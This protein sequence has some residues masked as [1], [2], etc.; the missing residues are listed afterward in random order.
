VAA[1]V[2]TA[3]LLGGVAL[4]R[5]AAT[6]QAVAE[7]LRKA[8]ATENEVLSMMSLAN[9]YAENGR[10]AKALK[11][12]EETLALTKVKLGPEHYYTIVNMKKLADCYFAL[13][14]HAEA[15]MLCEQ[16][17]ALMKTKY[18][19]D[20]QNTLWF[21]NGLAST[22]ADYGRHAEALKLQEETLVLKKAKL[23][24]EDPQ[25]LLTMNFLA[26]S[27][28][29]VG[30]H[31]EALKM[32][33]QRLALMR[34]RL[35]P[36]GA[37]LNFVCDWLVLS[38]PLPYE[39]RDGAIALDE[40]QIPHA[41]LLRPR[42]GESFQAG[43]KRLVWKEHHSN[44]VVLDLRALY[45]SPSD[46]RLSYAVCYVHVDADRN[47]L[48]LRVG[49]DDQ[50]S[51]T[52]NGK[53][54]YRRSAG[55]CFEPDDDEVKPIALRKGSNLLVFEVVNQKNFWEGSLHFVAADG[56]PA[57]GLRFGLEP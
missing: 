28:E 56:R 55:R 16:T 52:L 23:S 8:A 40:Q 31:A 25:T 10:Y 41:A 26:D 29:A 39:G 48:A 22:Y 14:R 42:A 32:R 38:E 49:S 5:S 4:W 18:G 24:P 35:G 21:M 33:K 1:V 2:L 3:L 9:R 6:A 15:F 17:L 51:V 36:E 12:Y 57:E 44:D 34:S 45:G 19:P 54:V 37:L 47:D 27:Y 20:N 46:Y 30:R 11:L 13:G 53:E 7:D 50:A 43:G